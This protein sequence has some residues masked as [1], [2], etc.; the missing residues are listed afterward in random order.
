MLRHVDQRFQSVPQLWKV[1]YSS[2]NFSAISP[3]PKN[4]PTCCKP[5]K[6]SKLPPKRKKINQIFSNHISA[7][8]YTLYAICSTP[9]N[10]NQADFPQKHPKFTPGVYPR[11]HS[12]GILPGAFSQLKKQPNM[13]GLLLEGRSSRQS[14]LLGRL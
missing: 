4:N 11:K 9:A 13:I 7:I 14:S 10:E 2:G 12:L 5:L 3:F 6:Y 8:R 1:R